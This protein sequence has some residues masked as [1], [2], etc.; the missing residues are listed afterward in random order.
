MRNGMH[1]I[2]SLY[3][4]LGFD[5]RIAKQQSN[6]IHKPD[7]IAGHLTEPG[8]PPFSV[9]TYKR[10]YENKVFGKKIKIPLPNHHNPYIGI[11]VAKPLPP[12]GAKATVV[13]V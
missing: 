8:R 13:Q 12:K 9:A 10:W 11:R 3:G 2:A 7:L 6:R 4:L 1:S 5:H